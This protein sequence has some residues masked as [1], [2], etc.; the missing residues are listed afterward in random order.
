[1]T[2]VTLVAATLTEI[3][4]EIRMVTQQQ[5]QMR[6][7]RILNLGRKTGVMVNMIRPESLMQRASQFETSIS[8]TMAARKI[9]QTHTN[10]RMSQ[11]QQV[12]LLGAVIH[13]HFKD[14]R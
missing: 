1:M 3:F 14:E 11:I 10:I 7:G 13:S 6:R 4:Q 9:I 8:L 12:E 5:N 2:G